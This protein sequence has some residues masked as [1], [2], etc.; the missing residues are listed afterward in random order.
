MDG[1]P[2]TYQQDQKDE[3]GKV[4]QS[5]RSPSADLYIGIEHNLLDN[6]DLVLARAMDRLEKI[7]SETFWAIPESFEFGQA[8]LALAKRNLNINPIT[9]YV[10]P[11]GVGLSKY[12]SHLEEML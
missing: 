9:L 7:Y 11:G 3:T 4:V 12:T 5:A 2:V 10:G 1:N 6:V 8:C